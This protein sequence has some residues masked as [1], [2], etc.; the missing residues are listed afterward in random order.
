MDQIDF[1]NMQDGTAEEYAFLEEQATAYHQAHLVEHVLGQL[2]MMAGPMLG[3]KIDRYEHSL[4][5]ATRA[6]R[7]GAEEEMVVAALLHDIGDV[8]APDN[9]SEY[10]AAVLRPYVSEKTYWIVKHHGIFQ[11]YY[12]WHHLG[13]DRDARERYREHPWFDDCAK[14]CADYDQNCFDP[15][16]ENEPL[17]TFEPMVRRVFAR[18]PW[19]QNAG[20]PLTS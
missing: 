4:Q 8:V 2:K 14:F 5:S 1:I 6:L 9:H 15:D 11:G 10:A 17:E 13:G 3:Y 12:F 19:S 16:Y 18:K 20:S 7:D